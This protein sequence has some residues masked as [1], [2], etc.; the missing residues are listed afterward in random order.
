MAFHVRGL[1]VSSG[2]REIIKG[3]SFTL[4]PGTV[5][6]IMG[7]NGSG[8]S[9]LCNALMGHPSFKASG[10]AKLDGKELLGLP[11]DAR[12]RAGLFLAFQEPEEMEGV[13]VSNFVRRALAAKKGGAKALDMD[14]MV[15]SFEKTAELAERLRLGK[16]FVSRELNAGFSGGE[17]KRMEMLQMLAFRPSVIIMD[18]MDSGLDVDGIRLIAGAIKELDDGKRCFLVITHYPRI[19]KYLKP[20]AVHVLAGGRI[21]KTGNARLAREIDKKGYGAYTKSA[22]GGM[23]ADVRR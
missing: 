23:A 3:I 9:T 21:A 1:R 13:K 4:R 12:A 20:D 19:L 14:A 8:K 16:A 6:A 2:G 15:K 11:P 5:T 22:A 18:E 7:P 17:K 10:S